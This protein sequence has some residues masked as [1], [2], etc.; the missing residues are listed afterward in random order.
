VAD[1]ALG[2]ALALHKR[3]TRASMVS[4]L[5]VAKR[6]DLLQ[7]TS[8]SPNGL[9]VRS[10]ILSRGEALNAMVDMA[11]LAAFTRG[12]T[13]VPLTVRDGRL[14]V[15]G[16]RNLR[17]DMPALTENQPEFPRADSKTSLH[18]DD[19]KW[20]CDNLSRIS[21]SDLDHTAVLSAECDGR[22]WRI[23]YA[24]DLHGACAFG[25][26]KFKIKFAVAHRDAEALR[27]MLDASRRE[28]GAVAIG[29][30]VGSLILSAGAH[31]IAIPAVDES[32]PEREFM[33]RGY[34]DAALFM[35]QDL[36]DSL[37]RFAPISS[38]KYPKPMLVKITDREIVMSVSGPAG[39]IKHELSPSGCRTPCEF[40]ISHG[41]LTALAVRAHGETT[42]RTLSDGRQIERIILRCADL[43]LACT[44]S[45]KDDRW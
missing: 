14:R 44:T 1:D 20:L 37:S 10:T 25:V 35:A 22:E 8:S 42:L 27:F 30:A 45:H 21:V 29:H 13:D 23:A 9:L 34:R 31:R 6:D 15:D 32:P 19:V 16:G 43:F 5:R 39:T 18:S 38:D 36:R 12:G 24:D 41:L 4:L 26:G 28:P 40:L 17:G 11:S 33:E 7:L 2:M 3:L